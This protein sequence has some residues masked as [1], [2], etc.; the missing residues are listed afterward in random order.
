MENHEENDGRWTEERLASLDPPGAWSPNT[1]RALGQI[2]ARQRA[3]RRRTVG[4]LCGFAAAAVA[5]FILLTLSAPQACATPTSCAEHFWDKVFPKHS[6]AP[7]PASPAETHASA[8]VN[9]RESGSPQAPIVCEIYS[10]YECPSC[11]AFYRDVMPKLIARYV[12]TGKVRLLHRD[13]PLARHAYSRIAARYANAAGRLGYYE[14]AVHRIFETQAA[15]STSGEIDA[16]LV[17]VLPPGVMQ[18]V[19][20]V[21][22]HDPSLDES[23][24]ADISQATADEVR[25]TPTLVVM[26][27]GKRQSFFPPPNYDLLRGYLDALLVQ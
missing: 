6:T 2:R 14:V 24:A 13:Y 9:F 11:A 3:W 5:C 23:V 12:E 8:P 1:A 17:P 27:K 4:V 25:G 16:Q 20:E 10:D 7:E 22:E 21:V 15:W 18:K 19:R 26:F